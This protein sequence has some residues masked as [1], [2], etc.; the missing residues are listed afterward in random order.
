MLRCFVFLARLLLLSLSLFG[1]ALFPLFVASFALFRLVVLVF[2][3]AALPTA[4]AVAAAAAA[5]PPAGGRVSCVS[6]CV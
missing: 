4:T 2:V 6:L 1:L 3:H 5:A